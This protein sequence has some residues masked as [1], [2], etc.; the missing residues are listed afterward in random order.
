LFELTSSKMK[1]VALEA[2]VL[3]SSGLN[4]TAQELSISC[5]NRSLMGGNYS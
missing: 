4:R 2:V 5:T 3:L 1:R